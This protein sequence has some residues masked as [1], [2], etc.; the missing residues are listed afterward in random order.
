MS[1]VEAPPAFAKAPTGIAGFDLVAFGGL[2]AGRTTLV[3]GG[4]GTGKTVFALET[5][6]KGAREHDE[7]GLFVAFEESPDRIQANAASFAWAKDEEREGAVSYLDARPDPDLVQSGNFDFGGL[8]A[9][10]EAKL[11]ASGAKRIVFDGLDV[12]LALLDSQRS[13]R[14]EVYV[15]HNWLQ[16]RQLTALITAKAEENR[17]ATDSVHSLDFLDFM[18]DCAVALNQSMLSGTSQR[19]LRVCKY[20]GSTFDE[21][22]IPFVIGTRGFEVAY[23]RSEDMNELPASTERIT[24]GV[25]RLDTMLGGGY[26]RGASILITG[27]PGTAKTTLSGAFA[28][29]ASAR[30]EKTLFVSFDSSREEIVRNLRSVGIDLQ[31]HLDSGVLRIQS[32]RGITKS[33]ELHYLWIKELAEA[34]ET[35]CLVVDP[36][37]ALGKS[38]N[39]ET[40]HSVAERLIDWAKARQITVVISSLLDQSHEHVEGTPLQISTIADT[41]LHLKYAVYAGERN[42]SISIVKS[43]GTEHSNQLREL[44]LS[45]DGISLADVYASG[46]EVLMGTLRWSKER[47]ERLEEYQRRSELER[48]RKQREFEAETLRSRISALQHELEAKLEESKELSQTDH[49]EFREREQARQTMREKRGGDVQSGAGKDDDR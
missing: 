3:R 46:G 15:L 7:P 9:V 19:S 11:R 48:M 23:F 10:I 22:A 25:P 1:T 39:V 14:R 30:G 2:P 34:Q 8:L 45:N 4:P 20:R 44:V 17:A 32:M 49:L 6:I 21:N 16:E 13:V 37:S 41:W 35:R 26:F 27:S 29:A 38:G 33:A 43:R 31:P 47:A 28:E 24:S 5:L 36:V 40:S 12:V 18:V 42:R